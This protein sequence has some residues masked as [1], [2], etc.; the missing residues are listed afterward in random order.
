MRTI[1]LYSF[2]GLVLVMSCRPGGATDTDAGAGE[3]GAMDTEKRET[4]GADNPRWPDSSTDNDEHQEIC[5]A[6][7]THRQCGDD[8]C[9]GNCGI[10]AETNTCNE[11]ACEPELPEALALVWSNLDDG[12]VVGR[13]KRIVL[14][15]GEGS[16]MPLTAEQESRFATKFAVTAA[17]WEPETETEGKEVPV[18]LVWRKKKPGIF[19]WPALVIVPDAICIGAEFTDPNAG[20][21][22]TFFS[23]PNHYRVTVDLGGEMYE[24]K[25]STVN[26]FS[27]LFK[28]VELEVPAGDCEYCPPVP[29]QVTV[30]IPPGY[31]SGNPQYVNRSIPYDNPQQRYPLLLVLAPPVLNGTGL[32]AAVDYGGLFARLMRG[33]MEPL[34]VA[35]IDGTLPDD[36]CGTYPCVQDPQ[37]YCGM[38]C[39]TEFLSF[40]SFS[41]AP[42]PPEADY[43]A[44]VARHLIQYLGREFRIRGRADDGSVL[45]SEAARRATGIGGFFRGGWGAML[46]AFAHP[47][48]FGSVYGLMVDSPSLFNPHRYWYKDGSIPIEQVCPSSDEYPLVPL[49]DGFRDLSGND[50]ETGMPR[51]ITMGVRS[52]WVGAQDCI[53]DTTVTPVPNEIVASLL[54]GLD[55]ACRVDPGAPDE[56]RTDFHKYPFDGN[57]FFSTGIEDSF[58]PPAAFFDLDQQLDKRSIPHTFRYEDRGGTGHDEG[59][60]GDQVAGYCYNDWE[61]NFE[62]PIEPDCMPPGNWENTG[63]AFYHFFNN[64]FEGL[65]NHPFNHPDPLASEFTAGALDPD[66][67]FYIDFD[68]E[69]FVDRRFV[70]DNCPGVPNP[71]QRDSDGDGVGDACD[72]D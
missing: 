68:Y 53:E 18:N 21:W 12:D 67:D 59:A 24:R 63:G 60:L 35:I 37:D 39:D 42:G 14:E 8:G 30:L 41:P 19:R 50:P 6:D 54:C 44:F 31:H 57:I 3:V 11:G 48:V 51:D 46:G 65:G 20:C 47:D 25:F 64:A 32:W 58:G 38:N 7:C 36:H 40:S 49:G 45:E 17:F 43:L 55:I 66:R 71:Y 34:L 10:C 28:A 13:G 16:P 23:W 29:V 27:G 61:I 70:E 69:D 33:Q 26:P 4:D 15:F 1:T 56:W 62:V 22:G 9:G 5:S 52:I 2:C 72:G